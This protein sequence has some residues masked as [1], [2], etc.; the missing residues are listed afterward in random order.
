VKKFCFDSWLGKRSS[1]LWITHR[2]WRPQSLRFNGC[3][4]FFLRIWY[5]WCESKHYYC[6]S[7]HVDLYLRYSV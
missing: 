3:R 6:D 4:S 2:L 1:V 5:G 7:E